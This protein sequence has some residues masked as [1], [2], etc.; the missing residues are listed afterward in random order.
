MGRRCRE[1]GADA[2]CGGGCLLILEQLWGPVLPS[3]AGS[4]ARE[5]RVVVG[6]PVSWWPAPQPWA[7]QGSGSAAPPA[8]RFSW[9]QELS[10]PWSWSLLPGLW[11]LSGGHHL[12]SGPEHLHLGGCSCGPPAKLQVKGWCQPASRHPVAS[13][14]A[15]GRKGAACTW[16][17][18]PEPWGP[19]L[20][21]RCTWSPGARQAP[22]C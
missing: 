10:V 7:G 20:I 9:L 2:G 14:R 15:E 18:W 4:T 5:G 13:A 8:W 3:W 16:P 17:L 12:L 1:A 6:C 11:L 19:G 22:G 21:S